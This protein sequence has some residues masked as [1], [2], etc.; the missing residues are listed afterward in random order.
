MES[1]LGP[2]FALE[3]NRVEAPVKKTIRPRVTG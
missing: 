3:D 1:I 2:M